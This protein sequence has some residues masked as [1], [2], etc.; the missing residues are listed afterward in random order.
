MLFKALIT[1]LSPTPFGIFYDGERHK[2]REPLGRKM[3]KKRGYPGGKWVGF[4]SGGKV[5]RRGSGNEHKSDKRLLRFAA[6]SWKCV[7]LQKLFK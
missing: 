1:S 3:V 7:K 4:G 5:G 6:G 2:G